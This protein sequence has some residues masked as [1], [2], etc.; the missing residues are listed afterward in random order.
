MAKVSS[1]TY[2]IAINALDE[3]KY[4]EAKAL[5]ETI[6]DY[7]DSKDKVTECTYQKALSL[8]AEKKYAEA[9]EIL[10]GL[11]DYS[12][13]KTKILDAKY[14]YVNEHFSKDDKTTVAYLEDLIEARY[15]DSAAIRRKLLGASALAD[16]VSSCI[17]YDEGDFTTNL[18][19]VENSKPIYFHVTVADQELYGKK[20]TVKFTTSVG[21]TERKTVTFTETDNT[22]TL[23]YPRTNITGY[24]VDF[25]V[26][27]ADGTELTKQTVTIK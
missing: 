23:M 7:A 16:G 26:L 17:N 11:G 18:E 9:I 25:S 27:A 3:G 14:K 19:E 10:T 6:T 12:E 1:C 5:F 24:T 21:Y 2:N 8:V 22:Y 13:S 15:L 4:D 20:L